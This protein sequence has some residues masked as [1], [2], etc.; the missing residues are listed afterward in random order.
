M[1]RNLTYTANDN[2]NRKKVILNGVNGYFISGQITGIMGPSGCGKSTLLG[3]IAGIKTKGLS[4][5]ITI[6]TN[7]KVSYKN[8]F[9]NIRKSFKT[10]TFR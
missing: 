7:I 3:C 8:Y 9:I 4:G 2:T 6:S 5:S 10:L 1:W